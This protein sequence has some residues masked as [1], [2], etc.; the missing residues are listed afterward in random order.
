M[1]ACECV[2]ACENSQFKTSVRCWLY[3]ITWNEFENRVIHYY[4][5]FSQ[6]EIFA[7]NL[8][9][10]WISCVRVRIWVGAIEYEHRISAHRQKSTT[11]QSTQQIR[12]KNTI[13]FVHWLKSD[14]VN[15]YFLFDG[16]EKSFVVERSH[17][18][19]IKNRHTS[20]DASRLLV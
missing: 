8:I 15:G 7:V 18:D 5:L 12:T 16:F 9:W 20:T 1:R 14:K 13:R 19:S 4:H 11:K 6:K 17:W 3:G 10:V 2:C